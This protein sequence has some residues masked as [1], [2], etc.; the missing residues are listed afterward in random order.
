MSVNV[1]T[2]YQR[3]L[4][5]TNKEQRGYI[6]PQEFNYMANQAQLDIF[7]QYFYDLNQFARLPGNSTEYSDMLDILEEKISLFEKVGATVTGGITLPS[8]VYR[9]GSILYNGIDAEHITQKNWLYI[10]KSPLSQPSNDFPVYL[11]DSETNAIKVY[12]DSITANKTTD[13][14]C[15]YIKTPAEVKW[16]YDATTGLYDSDS[17]KTTHFELHASE[18]TEL[19]VKI[20]ALAGIVLK[21]PGLYQIGSAEE[22]KNVQQEKA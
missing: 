20:L 5:I 9:L 10:K 1:N 18:E 14:T 16:G 6:T 19:V 4:A 15:N 21:D 12:A 8:D 2:V 13:V 3:V 11:R 22:V 7:E 17:A